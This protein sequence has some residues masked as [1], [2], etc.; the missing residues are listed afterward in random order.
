MSTHP[1]RKDK[2]IVD[3]STLKRILRTTKYVTLAFSKND[4]PYLVTLSHGYDETKNCI[5]FHCAGEG[6]KLDYI[7]ANNKVW[8]Q[9][10]LDYGYRE[11]ECTHHYA[12][13][14]FKGNVNLLDRIE[15]K[16]EAMECMIRQLDG[17]PEQL[18]AKL[19]I[20]RLQTTVLVKINIE[21]LSGKKSPEVNIETGTRLT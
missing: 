17:H 21:C 14:Q 19:K 12:T 11:G 3:Q 20:D 15:E 6:K 7:K 9:A 13:V 18:L 5:Y 2:E 8:G 1:R 10:M 16:R 4:E